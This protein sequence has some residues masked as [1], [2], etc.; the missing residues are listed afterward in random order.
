M[1]TFN[2]A[3]A[4]LAN[5]AAGENVDS[6]GCELVI[7]KLSAT[8]SASSAIMAASLAVD[9]NQSTRWE[10]LHWVDPSS[11]I[12]DLGGTFALS[13]VIICWEAANADTYKVQGSNDNSQWTTLANLSGG[14]F[15]DRTDS[16]VVAGIYRCL[17]LQL[18]SLRSLAGALLGISYRA[19]S[20]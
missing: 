12:L 14:A 2:Q 8:A 13:E 20:I 7:N 10:S 6:D 11:L 16:H 18:R 1:C 3:Y 17:R 4:Q 19:S 9:G 15:G 5:T